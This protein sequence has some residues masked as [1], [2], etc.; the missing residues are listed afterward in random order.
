VPKFILGAVSGLVPTAKK[1]IVVVIDLA[2]SKKHYESK[3]YYSDTFRG[4]IEFS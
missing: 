2:E 1:I 4:L 3:E